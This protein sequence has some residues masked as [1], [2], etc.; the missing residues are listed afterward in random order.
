[1]S[2][3]PDCVLIE[4]NVTFELRWSPTGDTEEI[5]PAKV[6]SIKGG[7]RNG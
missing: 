6:G 5:A 1:M 7:L 2:A 4:Q 3:G